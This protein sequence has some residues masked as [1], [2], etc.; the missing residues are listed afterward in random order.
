VA[1][2]RSCAPANP[3]TSVEFPVH[4]RSIAHPARIQ[5]LRAYSKLFLDEESQ[6]ILCVGAGVLFIVQQ[7]INSTH[8]LVAE[9]NRADLRHSRYFLRRNSGDVM[10][11]IPSYA[12]SGT[13]YPASGPTETLGIRHSRAD[14]G[15]MAGDGVAGRESSEPV[16]PLDGRI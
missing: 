4:S 6:Q 3:E 1:R 10:S 12:R 15:R 2:S 11:K 5:Y 13:T 9:C 14:H 8:D 16:A 7:I